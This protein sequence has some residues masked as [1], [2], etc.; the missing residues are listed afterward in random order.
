MLQ[1][2]AIKIRRGQKHTLDSFKF[3]NNL[4]K[5][6]PNY[7]KFERIYTISDDKIIALIE[8]DEGIVKPKRIINY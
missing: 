8:I 3:H 5:E 6:H 2:E 7:K 4:I 1:L